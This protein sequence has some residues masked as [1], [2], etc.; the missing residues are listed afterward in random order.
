M[1]KEEE[2][3]DFFSENPK[4]EEEEGA[5]LMVFLAWLFLHY[6]VSGKRNKRLRDC[7]NNNCRSCG[8]GKTKSG[9]SEKK[10]GGGENGLFQKKCSL[11]IEM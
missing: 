5:K 9:L 10:E 8:R 4:R 11:W 6:S 7:E 1:G 3:I 2:D